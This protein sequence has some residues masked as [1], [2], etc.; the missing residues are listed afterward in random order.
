MSSSAF[1]SFIFK[2]LGVLLPFVSPVQFRLNGT[3]TMGRCKCQKS[4][5]AVATLAREGVR[6]LWFLVRVKGFIGTW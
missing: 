1:K 2:Y 5:N 4:G 3:E 6:G